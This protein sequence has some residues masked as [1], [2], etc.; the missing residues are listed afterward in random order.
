MRGPRVALR[1][2]SILSA[3]VLVLVLVLPAAA[4][5]AG[6]ANLDEGRPLPFE[7]PYPVPRGEWSFELGGGYEN[8][9]LG[10]YQDAR[11]GRDQVQ[12]PLEIVYGAVLNAQ[13]SAGIAFFTHKDSS[14]TS[15]RVGDVRVAGLYNFSQES[16]TLPALGLKY[17]LDLPTGTDS[18]GVDAQV[19][20]LVTK[21]ISRVSFH[22]NFSELL[23]GERSFGERSSRSGIDLGSS[24]PL[25]AMH[26]RTLLLVGW[27]SEQAPLRGDDNRTGIEL[28]FRRQQTT[29]T[30]LRAGIGT[31]SGGGFD[32]TSVS[33]N[34]GLSWS[35]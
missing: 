16:T 2:G 34:A 26:T 6:H 14:G 15:V 13:I 21:S 7:D 5:A 23:I 22:A 12:F 33:V 17:T 27:F 24:F 31:E 18:H 4:L 11:L 30:V 3:A 1:A 9:R 35:Y 32:G 28:G 10:P 29:R 19:K 20:A 25:G 8:R